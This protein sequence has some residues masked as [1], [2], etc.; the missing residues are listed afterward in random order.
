[1]ERFGLDVAG[2]LIKIGGIIALVLGIF[3]IIE[4]VITVLVASVLGSLLGFIFP[5]LGA[6]L[7]LI[8]IGGTILAAAHIVVGAVL[9][10]ISYSLIKLSTPLPAN[11]R[12][13]WV[14]ILAVLAAL[15][16]IFGAWSLLVG[17][18]I[19]LAGLLLAPV[20]QPGAREAPPPPAPGS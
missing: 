15:A 1:M 4:G 18:G 14:A 6:L 9:A 8:P 3:Q 19:S 10:A 5:G 2:L 13:R 17:L 20:R 11:E 16:L 7:K 12:N